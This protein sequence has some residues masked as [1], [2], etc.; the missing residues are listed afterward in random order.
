MAGDFGD[1][2]DRVGIHATTKLLQAA[3]ETL[4]LNKWARQD[5]MPANSGKTIT[6]RR[7]E[8]LDVAVSALVGSNTPD[9]IELTPEDITANIQEFGSWVPVSSTVRDT[10]ED[11]VLM[12]ASEKLSWQMAKTLETLTYNVVKGGTSE[13]HAGSATQR[14]EVEDAISLKDFRVAVRVLQENDAR[15]YTKLV[16]STPAFNTIGIQQSY[17]GYGHTGFE[18]DLRKISG[19]VPTNEYPPGVIPMIGEVGSIEKVRIVLTNIALPFFGAGD[20]NG[21]NV[22]ETGGQADVYPM[23]FFAQESFACTRLEGESGGTRLIVANPAAH[24]GDELAQRGSVGW[25][26]WYACA[27]LN[28]DF[29]HRVEAAISDDAGVV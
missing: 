13:S 9:G 5:N 23:I 12:V 8:N 17:F 4:M 18:P 25:R 27:I 7:Y 1:I 15:Q 2:S 19:F 29:L 16:R 10:T 24:S 28:E 20:S 22:R 11:P 6:W 21:T 14:S 3:K 26:T